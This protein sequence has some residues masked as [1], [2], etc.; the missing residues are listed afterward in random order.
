[1]KRFFALILLFI[2][3]PFLAPCARLSA[4]ALPDSAPVPIVFVHGNGDDAAK[5]VPTIWLFESNG[6][7]ANRLFAIRFTNPMARA[8]DTAEQP[9][10]SSSTDEAAEL[11]AFV[12]RVLIQT[13]SRQVVLVGSSRGGLVIRNYLQNGGGRH[14]VAAAILCGTPNHGVA[15][16]DRMP[17]LEFNGGGGFLRALN[18]ANADGS[19]VVPGVRM[20]TLRSD[21][22]DKYAQPMMVFPGGG[23]A[24][25]TGITYAGPELKGATN[26][27]LAGADH[28]ELAFSS[29]AFAYIFK[30][31]TGREPK[32]DSPAPEPR[33]AL[34]GLVTAFAG[35]AP[36]NQ[37]LASVHLRIYAFGS[38]AN[39][40]AENPAYEITTTAT[41]AWGPFTADSNQKYEFD[42]ESEGRHVRY[43]YAPIPRSTSLLNLRFLPVPPE[44]RQQSTEMFL[45][46]RPQ[47]YFS[48][49]RDPVTIDGAL[50]A[51]EP[52]G[53]PARDSFFVHVVKPLDRVEV[54]LRKEKIAVHPSQ[55]L[56]KDLAVAEFLW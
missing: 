9:F 39:A 19:E 49:E 30:F 4:A 25:P 14:N 18:G 22:F 56:S 26:I 24:M 32:V 27:V 12:T 31:I 44:A 45:I 16:S 51:E 41:G 29:A 20:M 42:L 40:Q 7:P 48:R 13:R 55:D 33:P 36:T 8:D 34:S 43:F 47:G 15:V 1:M 21:K 10:H 2:L 37:P 3:A 46:D 6:Y 54:S 23:P 11:S 5:W 50:A 35:E 53:L 52:S 17:N 28:C 38:Q